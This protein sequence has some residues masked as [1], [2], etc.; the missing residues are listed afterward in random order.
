MD[1]TIARADVSPADRVLRLIGAIDL[2]TRDE[3][4]AAGTEA[5]DGNECQRLTVDLADVDF[6]DSTGLG[7]LVELHRAAE[8]GGQEFIVANP[9]ARARRI[10][11]ITGL[12]GALV[13]R[14]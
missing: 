14:G 2:A 12:D 4:L 11:E 8:D 5:L 7:T 9:S 6:I 13:I 1:L 10:L 3:L